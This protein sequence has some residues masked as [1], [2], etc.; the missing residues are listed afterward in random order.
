MLARVLTLRFDPALEAFD[1]GPLQEFLKAREVHAIRE[2]FFVRDGAPYLAVLVTYGLRPVAAPAEPAA[3]GRDASWRSQV[4]EADLPLFNALRDWR[5]ERAKRDGVRPTWS[6]PTSNWPRWSMPD[7]EAFPGSRRSTASARRSS[8]TT[9]R[10]FWPCW[11]VP[12]ARRIPRA[13]TGPILRR[14]RRSLPRPV[15]GWTPDMVVPRDGDLPVF[16]A[17]LDFL[18]WLLPTTAKLPKHVRFTFVNRIDNLALDI[19]EDL[20]EAAT[21]GTSA[22]SWTAPISASNGSGCSCDCATRWAISRTPAATT[23]CAA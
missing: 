5:A 20:V 11:R 19:A 3:K 4:S 2:H 14:P 7:R 13:V 21:A 10:S 8:T 1:D 18:E 12:G 16:V 22:A 15:S 6:A 23:R 9:A 17:W